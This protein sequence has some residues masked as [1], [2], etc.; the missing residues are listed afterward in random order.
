M[1]ALNRGPVFGQTREA[2]R[3]RGESGM[4][5]DEQPEA[6]MYVYESTVHCANVLLCLNDQRKQDLLCDVT[7]LAEG[8]E[9][10]AH[11]AVLAACSEYF[12]QVLAGQA[13]HD[14]VIGLPEETPLQY[15]ATCFLTRDGRSPQKEEVAFALLMTVSRAWLAAQRFAAHYASGVTY[16]LRAASGRFDRCQ[17]RAAGNP[18]NDHLWFQGPKAVLTRS[19]RRVSP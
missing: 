3:E 7:V 6:P 10:R 18:C 8:K 12:L 19:F 13:E 4:S 16:E 1:T 14:P 15:T 2:V 9:F 5:V 11:R 17:T